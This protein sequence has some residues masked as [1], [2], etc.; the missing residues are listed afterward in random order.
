MGVGPLLH[1]PPRWT[2]V[3]RAN[4][5]TLYAERRQRFLTAPWVAVILDRRR[6]DRRH[7]AERPPVERRLAQRRAERPDPNVP[8]THRLS[9]EEPGVAVYELMDLEAATDCPMC[10][11]TVWFEMPR[12]SE[13]PPDLR[14]QVEHEDVAARYSRHFVDLDAFGAAGQSLLSFRAMA[15]MSRRVR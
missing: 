11:A 5:A 1:G 7:A 6:S 2:I 3:V 12:F 13:P 9:H 14:L 10:R 4:D 8:R 15:R